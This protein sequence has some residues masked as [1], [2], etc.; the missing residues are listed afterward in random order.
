[1]FYIVM[2]GLLV[3]N[4]YIILQFSPG[5]TGD[6]LVLVLTLI[7]FVLMYKKYIKDFGGL[8]KAKKYHRKLLTAFK[9]SNNFDQ[10]FNN[11]TNQESDYEI[12]KKELFKI[13][14]K[15]E[16]FENHNFYGQEIIINDKRF[17]VSKT[18]W[19]FLIF[20]FLT[21]GIFTPYLSDWSFYIFSL[22][23]FMIIFVALAPLV[24]ES[25]HGFKKTG[26]KQ[27]FKW[28]FL[29]VLMIFI[30]NLINGAFF[31]LFNFRPDA[32]NQ[33]ILEEMLHENFFR[34]AF[35]ATFTAA[36]L[37]EFVFRGIFFRNLYDKNKFLAY[38]TTFI[39]FGIPHLFAGLIQGAG[40]SELM[41]LPIYGSLGLVM[42]F[43]YSKTGSIFTAMGT[44][45]I[46]N[47]ISILAVSLM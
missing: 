27:T 13:A 22:L 25:Y 47:L 40:L 11:S 24:I 1:M 28:M 14:Y 41:F 20:T 29:G 45:F 9:R 32:Q 4:S 7:I 30:L 16:D 5:F 39:A 34:V 33:I 26:L 38:L 12:A 31:E 37:E 17:M 46:N 35:N 21:T 3:F 36:I 10:N 42:A 6:L 15:I 8:E 44:H 19:A 18:R 2:Y 23:N 43:V